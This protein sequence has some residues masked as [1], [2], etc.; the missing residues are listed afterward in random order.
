[1]D[2][3]INVSRLYNWVNRDQLLD[4]LDMYGVDK[5]HIKDEPMSNYVEEIDLSVFT[6]N[7][8]YEFEDRVL[9]LIQEQV[10]VAVLEGAPGNSDPVFEQTLRLMSEDREAIY[11]GLVRDDDRMVFGV[12]DLIIRGDARG[13]DGHILRPRHQIHVTQAQ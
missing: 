9:R 2:D 3:W 8:G 13:P 10:D 11:Q 5:G 12:P 4:W 6:R 7:K 1:M